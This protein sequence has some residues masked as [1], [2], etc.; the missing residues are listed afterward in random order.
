MD[1][2]S[3]FDAQKQFVCKENMT[4]CTWHVFDSMIL[5]NVQLAREQ[6]LGWVWCELA[7]WDERGEK[8]FARHY[9][10]LFASLEDFFPPSM[11]ACSQVDRQPET[12]G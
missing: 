12:T 2:W 6:A 10:F 7:E 1:L 5:L 9:V 4:G 3:A 8:R 11:A